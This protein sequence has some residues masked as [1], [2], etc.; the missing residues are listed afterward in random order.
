[1]IDEKIRVFSL[2]ER[3]RILRL[4]TQRT[5]FLKNDASPGCFSLRLVILRF[6][7]T[8]GRDGEGVVIVTAERVLC[9]D[10]I[11]W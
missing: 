8:I 6:D 4:P 3:N 10:F 1:M 11:R 5:S 2:H 7:V 9:L